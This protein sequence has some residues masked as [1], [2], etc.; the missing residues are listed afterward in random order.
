MARLPE[1][2]DHNIEGAV[3]VDVAQR[4][5]LG[6][7]G[8]SRVERG[9]GRGE[10]PLPIIQVDQV[11]EQNVN[12]TIAVE[13][14]Q[15]HALGMVAVGVKRGGRGGETRLAVVQIDL[16]RPII[17]KQNINGAVAVD[18]AQHHTRGEVAGRVER[19]RGSCGE[20]AQPVVQVDLAWLPIVA[21]QNVERP[22]AV[23]VTERHAPGG[24]G[25]VE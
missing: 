16:A 12:R 13:V 8:G 18:V 23:E 3:T 14:A 24:V 7:V 19:D 5:A 9:G 4:R 2:A 25:G 10:V 15:R 21:E 6:A 11:A 17:A 22:V 1:V 20:A